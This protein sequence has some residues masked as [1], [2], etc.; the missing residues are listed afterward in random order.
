M[1]VIV[2]KLQLSIVWTIKLNQLLLLIILLYQLHLYNLTTCSVYFKS[3]LTVRYMVI[4]SP[5]KPPCKE[6]TYT[7]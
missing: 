7:V 2:A 5:P 3:K 4:K 1:N 6:Q